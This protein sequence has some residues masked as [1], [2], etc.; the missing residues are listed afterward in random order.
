MMPQKQEQRLLLAGGLM[1][2]GA[3]LNAGDTIIVRVLTEDIHPFVIVFFRSLFGLLFVAPW[4]FKN[5]TILASNYRFLH[6]LRAAL[7][8]LTLVAFFIAISKAALVDVTTIAFTTPV[9]VTLGAWMFL[10]ERLTVRRV[11]AVVFGFIGV[12]VILQPG[13]SDLSSALLYAVAGA[14]L[15]AV[16][17]LILKMM[18][19]K[20][21]TESLVAWNLILTVPI[22]AI[23][24][25]WFWTEPSWAQLS[26]LAVQGGVGAINMAIITRAMALADASFIAPI[27]FL[28]LPIIA[29]FAFFF[30]GEVLT[31]PTVVGAAIIF[32]STFFL[33]KRGGP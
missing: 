3:F 8:L 29:V 13:Q 4:I 27:D 18:S 1:V 20:D 24:C 31:L 33:A 7:K 14:I 12:F 17:Q 5:R 10:G 11:T 30:F 15:A 9:F 22:A 6:L 28:R 26:L 21:S 16:I 25:Y 2:I 23:P 32:A 19:S